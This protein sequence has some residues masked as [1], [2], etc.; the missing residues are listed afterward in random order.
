VQPRCSCP[1]W[2]DPCKH[3]A[4][5]CYLVADELDADPFAL[6]RLRG[7]ARD[8]VLAGLRARRRTG[9]ARATA[10][11]EPAPDDGVPARDA[12]QRVPAPLPAP[13]LP[14]AQPGHPAVLPADPPPGL[15]REDLVAL[16]ADAASRCLDLAQGAGDGGLGL[17]EQ[18][19]LARR[20]AGLLGTSG[21]TA[22][23]TAVG[24]PGRDL[25]SDAIAWRHGGC[26]GLA[27]RHGSWAPDPEALAEGRDAL[28]RSGEPGVT[29]A[30]RNRLTRGA[31]QLR[32]GP[33]GLW[34]RLTR[35]DKEWELDAGPHP[36]PAAV[37]AHTTP[38]HPY[39]PA[40]EE[41]TP[42]CPRP[43]TPPIGQTGRVSPVS[44]GR[45][46]RMNSKSTRPSARSDLFGG[47]DQCDCPACSGEDFDPQELIDELI[48]GAA[49]LVESEDPL[50]AEIAGA[51]FVSIGAIAGEEFEEALVGGFIPE[52]EARANAEALAMVLAIGSVAGD[53]VGKA[54]SAAADR[55]VQAGIPRPGWAAE[56]GEPVTVTDCWRLVDAQHTA[57]MLV[58]LFHRAGRS[59][60]VVMSVDHLDCDAAGDLLLFPVDQQVTALGMPA[61]VLEMMATNG[62]DSGVELM[63]EALDPAEFRWQVETALDARAV[64][65]SDEA[66]LGTYDAPDD[67][68]D[69]PDYRALAV[70]LRA[71][72]NALPASG[73]PP[74]PHGDGDDHRGRLSP[75]GLL[76]RLADNG[77]G[78]SPPIGRRGQGMTRLSKKRKT[79][80]G[81]APVYQLK[82]GLRG[83]KPPIWRRLE[84]PADISLAQLHEAV[85][86]AFDWDDSHMHVFETPSGDFGLA[87]AELGHRAE[88]PV[89]LEQVAPGVRSKIRYTYDF[90]DDWEHE[91]LVEKVLDR[92]ETASYPRCTGGRRAAPPED[93]GGVW[94]YADLVEVL[95]DPAHPEHEDRLEWLG[96]DDAAEFDPADFDATAVNQALTRVR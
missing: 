51:A 79:P 86:V 67:D 7:R 58:C 41:I 32:L 35:W 72:M 48:A 16:A 90:G 1:D 80:D 14:P 2:A 60:T 47:P 83:A 64:H 36:D 65:D 25:A 23:A 53:H 49:E 40:H 61:T 69:L 42:A 38:A 12:Y 39:P 19:D 87:D 6:L 95:A 10:A 93:C 26:G 31:V 94:G 75:V 73:K 62:R 74:A 88:A 21:F 20:A 84:V 43:P 9:S 44:R 66:E 92:D 17:S 28:N 24:V 52:F 96:L 81:A 8:E 18:Q 71:R 70:V 30:Y 57:S 59:H 68:D 37:L 91:I 56:L 82:V 77:A 46:G 27:V 76:A 54:A 29:R 50:D 5:V 11:P 63:K 3:A 15:R 33:D 85:Q 55:L 45:K 34:Y 13:P 78:A 4:A 22:L 89:T